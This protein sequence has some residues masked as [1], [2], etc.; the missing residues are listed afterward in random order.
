[1]HI[2]RVILPKDPRGDGSRVSAGIF[3]SM[4]GILLQTGSNMPYS[5]AQVVDKIID[6]EVSPNQFG[7][8]PKHH[9]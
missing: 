8:Q 1:M 5:I 9:M 7:I 4:F 6:F 3:V 2:G